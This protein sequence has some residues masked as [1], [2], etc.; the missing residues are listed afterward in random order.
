MIYKF[1][2]N[3]GNYGDT[4]CK[5]CIVGNPPSLWRPETK[6]GNDASGGADHEC[7]P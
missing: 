7:T 4:V 2:G 1:C 6:D 5:D 3:C